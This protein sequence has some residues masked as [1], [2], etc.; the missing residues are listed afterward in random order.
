MTEATQ[1]QEPVVG[2]APQAEA[3]TVEPVQTVLGGDQVVSTEATAAT[4]EAATPAQDASDTQSFIDT[5]GEDYKTVAT[6][7]GF[8]SVDDVM[9]SYS[10]LEG[11]MGK[12]FDELTNEE[13]TSVY[14]KLG[15]PETAE[16]YEF[17]RAELPEGIDDNI[18]EWFAAKAHELG[19]N[20]D[21]AQKL[22]NEFIHKQAE[23]YSASLLNAN[24]TQADDIAAI[25]AEFGAA[26]EE[27]ASLASTALNEFGGEEV[28]ALVNQYGLQN[29]PALV[30]MFAKIGELT[31]EGGLARDKSATS[32]SFGTTP[33]EAAS[34][35]AEKFKDTEFM[36]RWRTTSHPGH[37]DAV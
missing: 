5:L 15:A 34:K 16:G 32:V 9:K 31:A 8:K 13:L 3:A 36:N 2:T 4:P 23:E 6:Q 22:R 26:F 25:K 20:K 35:I 28:K 21:A 7:K 27:R 19:I 17:E 33:A 29:N 11:M 37:S 30:K 14:T 1:A 10:N 12:K 24:T 18:T